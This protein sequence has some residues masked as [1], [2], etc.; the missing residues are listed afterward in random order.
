MGKGE[1]TMPKSCCFV[2]KTGSVQ[3]VFLPSYEGNLNFFQLTQ[4]RGREV[5]KD[6]SAVGAIGK[7]I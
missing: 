5:N 3:V 1:N 6:Y 7:N 4:R 2:S